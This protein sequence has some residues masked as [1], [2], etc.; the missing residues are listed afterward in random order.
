MGMVLNMGRLSGD[1]RYKILKPMF[2]NFVLAT[3]AFDLPA[4]LLSRHL[5]CFDIETATPMWTWDRGTRRLHEN[6][7]A[8]F[9]DRIYY[10]R[11]V[12]TVYRQASRVVVEDDDGVRETF[13]EVVFARNVDQ[14]LRILDHP[15]FLDVIF[16]RRCVMTARSITTLSS[17]PTPR[18]FPT[19]K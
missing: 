2:I 9:R 16:S 3:N 4:A 17:T 12:R 1:F 18:S 10:N 15:T 19:T 5:E 7:S 11:P 6:L 14:T 13:D 8:D